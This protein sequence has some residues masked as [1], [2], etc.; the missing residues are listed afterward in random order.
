V[1]TGHK[2]DKQ[3]VSALAELFSGR[4]VIALG[5]GRGEYRKLILQTGKVLAYDSY[6]GA[7]NIYNITGGQV[8]TILCRLESV[9]L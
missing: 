2:T 7:P 8:K 6:D 5:D 3:L 1:S 4:T 9:R